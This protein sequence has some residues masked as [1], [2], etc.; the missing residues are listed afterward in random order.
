VADDR[1]IAHANILSQIVT[2]SRGTLA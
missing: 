2:K 1:E